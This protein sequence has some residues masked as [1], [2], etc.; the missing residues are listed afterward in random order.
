MEIYDAIMKAADH[1]AA[2]P[3]LFSYGSTDVPANECGAPG[4]ALGWI[5]FV[6]DV[7][8]EGETGLD[9]MALNTL[10]INYWGFNGFDD[11]MNEINVKWSGSAKQCAITLRAY[12]AKYHAPKPIGFTGLPDIVREIFTRQSAEA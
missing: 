10:G 11:R 4:C 6:M 9:G 7:K 3:H 2:K 8:R 12:A 1:I 5:C